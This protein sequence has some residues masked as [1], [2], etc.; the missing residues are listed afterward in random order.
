[1]RKIIF[2]ILVLALLVA[3]VPAEAVTITVRN[4]TGFTIHY[5]YISPVGNNEWGPEL[6]GGNVLLN[7]SDFRVTGIA[8]V[9]YNFYAVDEDGDSY[10]RANIGLNQG[11]GDWWMEFTLDH[12]DVN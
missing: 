9:R 8:G 5:L 3:A 4:R 11:S 12:I 6:L 10:T 7:G 1:M 2:G